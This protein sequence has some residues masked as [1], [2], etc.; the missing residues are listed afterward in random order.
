MTAL[1]ALQPFDDRIRTGAAAMEQA[2][3]MP[4]ELAAD[5]AAAGLFAQLV[6]GSLGGLELHPQVF[7]DTLAE[8]ARADGATGWV[9]MIGATTGMLSA[10]LDPEWAQTIYGNQGRTITTGV[11]APLGRALTEQG[12][13][14]ITGRWPFG[15]GSQV[16]DWI[17]GGCFIYTSAEDS[18]PKT[19]A[20]GAPEHIL[21]FFPRAEVT[22]H[23]TWDTSGLRGTGSHDIEVREAYV[24]Q[25]RW[26]ALGNR[27]RVD[28]PLYRFPTFGLLAL[29]VSA[30]AI[31]IAERAIEEFI[32]LAAGKVP[33]G[34]TRSLA[35]RALAQRDLAM[36]SANVRAARALTSSAIERAWLAAERT[37]KLSTEHKADLR[38]AA[39]NNAWRAA[40]AVDWLYHNAG[41][42]AI[43]ARSALQRCFRDVHVVTQHL[44]VAQPIFEVIGKVQLGIDP[45]TFL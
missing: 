40:E 11:T 45:K 19:G 24:P 36:A 1:A 6:P 37:G 22:I 9:L 27:A 34:S 14:R 15:S 23:D 10:S 26:V 41:G 5:M 8:A 3:Q 17:C 33:T 28:G 18:A 43:Y 2:R 38:L 7:F 35:N 25:G 32:E 20:N 4:A 29:G 12:G 39:S 30:V 21:A 42:S 13:L 16:S 44:M 31:G